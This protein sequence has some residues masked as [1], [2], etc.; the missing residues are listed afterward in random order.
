MLTN[1]AALQ[2]KLNLAMQKMHQGQYQQALVVF[3]QLEESGMKDFR[4][5]LTIGSAYQ[6]LKQDIKALEYF[7]KSLSLNSE[8]AEL[9]FIVGK[10]FKKIG[11]LKQGIAH[12][13]V[14]T[15]LES[16]NVNYLQ[17]LGFIRLMHKDFQIA[18]SIFLQT[19]KS[20]SHK[21]L[22]LLGIAR[23]YAGLGNEIERIKYI[24]LAELSD[25]N[26]PM[27]I[28]DKARLLSEQGEYVESKG[29]FK[30]YLEQRPS[31]DE[32][33]ENLAL[34]ELQL[35]NPQG[36]LDIID[37]GLS[38]LP[39]SRLLHKFKSSLSFEMGQENYLGNY[40]QITR[41][42]MPINLHTD[43]I[44][45][46]VKSGNFTAAE[47][48]FDWLVKKAP[49]SINLHA[50]WMSIQEKQQ[51]YE[52]ILDFYQK[53]G[54]ELKRLPNS[55]LEILTR[56]YFALGSFKL[57]I[58]TVSELVLREPNNQYFWALYTTSLRLLRDERYHELCNFSK[59][60][61]SREL[62]L[63]NRFTCIEDFNSELKVAL[64]TLHVTKEHP[65]EQSLISGTQ[66]PGELLN[67]PIPIIKE[68]NKA[69]RLT[70]EQVFSNLPKNLPKPLL[71]MKKEFEFSASWSVNLK[72]S[73]YHKSHVHS[74]G[75]FSSAY[76]VSV[77][78]DL[79]HSKRAGWLYLGKPEVVSTVELKAE[80]WVKPEPGKLVLFPSFM[81]HGTEPFKS[82]DNRLTVAFDI[83]PK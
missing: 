72:S 53:L 46:L 71:Q 42:K 50:L 60:V 33:Y 23:A 49:P 51:N 32:G 3:S 6:R 1:Q 22:A 15:K 11:E 57:S 10:M 21:T 37:A 31:N 28:N 24:G 38:R 34:I 70:A 63:P 4:L 13:E 65:L 19:V 44:Q 80:K 43:F 73:G 55:V 35:K 30:K 39:N 58:D 66:T 36:A 45:A 27:V 9:Q 83:L 40:Q 82:I 52:V 62:I 54:T 7:K 26:H 5:F 2:S 47:A 59:F 12:L 74:K 8:Q 69:L 41:N 76:Y 14:A 78:K 68:L 56:T 67:R 20:N 48:E 16:S 81:W 17:E 64:Q 79:N 29:Y 77:P 75:Y 25:P 61:Q 18:L